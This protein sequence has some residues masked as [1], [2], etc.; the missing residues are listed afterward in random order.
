MDR[1]RTERR[2]LI[3]STEQHKF[4]GQTLVNR[5][6]SKTESNMKYRNIILGLA[7]ASTAMAGCKKDGLPSDPVLDFPIL[8]L[9]VTVGDGDYLAVPK[10]NEDGTVNDTL[11]ID[12]D[13]GMETGIV[14][15]L[16]IADESST[17]NI[18]EGQVLTFTDDNFDIICNQGRDNEHKYV[19]H[20]TY[21]KDFMWLVIKGGSGGP[22]ATSKVEE[23]SP[24]LTE[25]ERNIFV[26]EADLTGYAWD[27][28][29]LVT[30][31]GT[32][33]FH[34]NGGAESFPA[35]LTL[36]EIEVGADGYVGTNGPWGNWNGTY[37]FTFNADTMQLT[38]TPKE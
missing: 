31:D 16:S 36:E 19:L 26:G 3:F 35:T 20:M 21:E 14:K 13:E 2:I 7:L 32:R 37:V 24:V 11:T 8:N 18:S 33:A 12:V 17:L 28:L 22:L 30:S 4:V 5:V 6:N 38:I 1:C 34:C 29:G 9:V 15:S 23:N 25:T 27:N 10:M